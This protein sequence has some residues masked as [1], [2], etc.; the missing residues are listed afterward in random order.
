MSSFFFLFVI[1]HVRFLAGVNLLSLPGTRNWISVGFGNFCRLSS[2]NAFFPLC[3]ISRL[4]FLSTSVFAKLRI[5][6]VWHVWETVGG[7]ERICLDILLFKS[8][9]SLNVD[10]PTSLMN[11]CQNLFPPVSFWFIR[12]CPPACACAYVFVVVLFLMARIVTRGVPP[13]MRSCY[14]WRLWRPEG[15]GSRRDPPCVPPVSEVFF[16]FCQNSADPMSLL[17]ASDA[18]NPFCSSIESPLVKPCC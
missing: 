13:W 5:A 17:S 4:I 1:S 15:I 16:F 8:N 12:V 11:S 3:V 7:S 10:F 2:I 18:V 6:P 14:S 9:F